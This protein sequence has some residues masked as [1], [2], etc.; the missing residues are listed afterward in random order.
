MKLTKAT[1]KRIIKEELE[2]TLRETEETIFPT[3]RTAGYKAYKIDQASADR[4]G[5]ITKRALRELPDILTSVEQFLEWFNKYSGS[6]VSE[7]PSDVLVAIAVEDDSLN[8]KSMDGIEM[9]SRKLQR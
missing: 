8:S 6:V 1:L 2:A 3:I 9:I 5:T 7:D 4:R